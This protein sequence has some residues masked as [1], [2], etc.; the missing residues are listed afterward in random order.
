[1]IPAAIGVPNRIGPDHFVMPVKNGCRQIQDF[2]AGQKIDR[3]AGFRRPDCDFI[4]RSCDFRQRDYEKR[5]IFC[6][7]SCFPALPPLAALYR[8]AKIIFMSPWFHLNESFHNGYLLH[9]W[10]YVLCEPGNNFSL[11]ILELTCHNK[12][13]GPSRRMSRISIGLYHRTEAIFYTTNS[14]KIF[15]THS[16]SAVTSL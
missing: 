1:M 16:E 14:T 10:N 2:L 8:L 5:M 6:P 9:E 3:I 4:A 15:L 13:F 7:V 11:E 12:I